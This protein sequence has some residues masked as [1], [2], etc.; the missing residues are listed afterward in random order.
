[1]AQKKINLQLQGD[2][3][4]SSAGTAINSNWPTKLSRSETFCRRIIKIGELEENVDKFQVRSNYKWKK[5]KSG[6]IFDPGVVSRRLSSHDA[7]QLA[8]H[9][10][11]V[12]S[13]EAAEIQTRVR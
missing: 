2:A 3:A 9:S 5:S 10:A 8:R 1:M 13:V 12:S 7:L 11:D 6:N 4:V